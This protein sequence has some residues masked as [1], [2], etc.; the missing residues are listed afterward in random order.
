MGKGCSNYANNSGRARESH[1]MPATQSNIRLSGMV[2][3][4]TC[5]DRYSQ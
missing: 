5:N 4:R 3:L 1:L 2:R